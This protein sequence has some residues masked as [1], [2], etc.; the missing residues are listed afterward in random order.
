MRKAIK[1]SILYQNRET[2]K[3]LDL[4]NMVSESRQSVIY[5]RN[6]TWMLLQPEMAWKKTRKTF[7]Y[8]CALRTKISKSAL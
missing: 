5:S 8:L 1:L 3:N 6:T 4:R 2:E 7:M